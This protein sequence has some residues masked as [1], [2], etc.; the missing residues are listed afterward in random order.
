MNTYSKIFHI[1][2]L[3]AFVLFFQ[4]NLKA[5]E[6]QPL[7]I[8]KIDINMSKNKFV[9]MVVEKETILNSFNKYVS[10]KFL[11]YSGDIIF[12][13]ESD[14]LIKSKIRLKGDS[15]D[16]FKEE[17]PSLRI[18]INDDK[19]IFENFDLNIPR[20]RSYHWDVIV[21]SL[22]NKNFLVPYANII[23]LNLASSKNNRLLEEILPIDKMERFKRRDGMILKF[24]DSSFFKTFENLDL[25]NS[26][27][28]HW[29]FLDLETDSSLNSKIHN[30][31]PS[32]LLITYLN[33]EIIPSDIFDYDET[34]SYLANAEFWCASHTAQLHNLRLFWDS[35][36][37][38]FTPVWWDARPGWCQNS[39]LNNQFVLLLLR[40]QQI[41]NRFKYYYL[42]F[43]E[44][45]EDLM[46]QTKNIE[47]LYEVY[48]FP[49]FPIK[50]IINNYHLKK[51]TINLL[52]KKIIDAKIIE[53]QTKLNQ[54]INDQDKNKKLT[55]FLKKSEN[56]NELMFGKR[57][58]KRKY[59]FLFPDSYD[60]SNCRIKVICKSF[61]SYNELTSDEKMITEKYLTTKKNKKLFLINGSYNFDKDL[62]IDNDTAL[63]VMP[64]VKINFAEDKSLINFGDLFFIGDSDAPITINSYNPSS[65]WGGLKVLS[66]KNN[67]GN[68]TILHT[69][70]NNIKRTKFFDTCLSFVNQDIFINY[71]QIE[72]CM[73]E[74]TINFI[75]SNGRVNN[76]N[77]S[78]SY[79]DAIDSDFSNIDFSNIVLNDTGGDGLDFSGSI[80]K[81]S[82]IF[83][84]NTDDKA[85]SVGETSSIDIYDLEV[86]N[87][88]FGVVSKDGS[89]TDINNA[90][91]ENIKMYDLAV[92]KKKSYLGPAELSA[93]F[94]NF[95]KD[96]NF[97]CQI[98]SI[99]L[100][101]NKFIVCDNF[102]SMIF[103]K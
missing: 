4:L 57:T 62:I 26:E 76:I 1:L 24:D 88:N 70:I 56:F 79:S 69:K 34:A 31:I 55:K 17:V 9:G 14:F 48:D 20:L 91:F 32:E 41:L 11:K 49:S 83:I 97:I 87:S 98:E 52:D 36:S 89:E 35:T 19:S 58:Y 66:N 51:E 99:F 2:Y 25:S 82:K 42:L 94:V 6:N 29:F 71:L 92:F 103:Y 15:I 39:I 72:N 90:K 59:E 10:H 101:D 7:E 50:N 27:F 16:H 8:N 77:I 74:D 95:S 46:K 96:D 23:E 60:I 61:I 40:D 37:L 64:G 86:S 93:N 53:L 85:I 102:D 67:K 3:I 81:I 43:D 38:Y 84:K 5:S 44:Q 63:F 75:Y 13:D 78:S 28:M 21:R 22:M 68:L 100:V 54:L 80:S 47:K 33:G 30:K 12:N 73:A 65:Y 18:S 45:I